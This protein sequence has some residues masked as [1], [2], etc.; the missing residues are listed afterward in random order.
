MKVINFL[1]LISYTL[2][3]G[4]GPKVKT[5]LSETSFPA[6]D[7]K[8]NVFL[9]FEDE[10]VPQSTTYVG[11]IKIGDSGFSTNCEYDVII[12]RVKTIARKSGAN[13][14]EVTEV[15]EPSM[16]STCYR[17]KAKLYRNL[18]EETI[19]TL[20]S[21]RELRNKSRLPE[22][23]DYAIIHFYRPSSYIG[24]AIGYKIRRN[25]EED[26][27]GK[28]R[29]GT[30]FEVKTKDFGNQRFWAKTEAEESVVIDVHKG[31]EYFV[32]CGIGMG[33]FVGQPKMTIVENRIGIRESEKIEF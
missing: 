14:I 21:N 31:Q 30:K 10:K 23:A 2:I 18:D 11:D 24:S 29:N 33:A 8:N 27:L 32:K 17:L 28:I 3:I 25:E 9:L 6:L 7:S 12:D 26:E 13:L 1:L 19:S 22:D 16:A 4:C 15:K 20:L 5:A